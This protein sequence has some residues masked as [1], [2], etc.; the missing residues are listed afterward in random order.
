MQSVM[1]QV[2][3]SCGQQLAAYEG[4]WESSCALLKASLSRCASR[5]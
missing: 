4:T 3:A 5:K 1:D 2:K